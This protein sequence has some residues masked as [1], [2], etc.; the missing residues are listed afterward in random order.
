MCEGNNEPMDKDFELYK[1]AISDEQYYR[2]MFHS[3]LSYHTNIMLAL[4][5]VIGAGYI[6]AKTAQHYFVI[7]VF[8]ALYTWITNQSKG[9]LQRIYDH[10]IEMLRFREELEVRL[11]LREISTLGKPTLDSTTALGGAPSFWVNGQFFKTTWTKSGKEIGYFAR[12]KRMFSVFIFIGLVS[13]I[14]SFS[15]GWIDTN[16]KP[17]ASQIETIK[18]RLGVIEKKLAIEEV[19]NKDINVLY[20]TLS[21]IESKINSIERNNLTLEETLL[22][23]ESVINLDKH[24]DRHLN[25]INSNIRSIK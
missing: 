10:F 9:A 5:T 2:Q 21:R 16:L 17:R 12:M 25:I 3:R 1:L 7:A 22:H 14:V 20:R 8:S 18:K 19:V 6:Q 23:H 24:L 4:L 13:V 15:K 11:G